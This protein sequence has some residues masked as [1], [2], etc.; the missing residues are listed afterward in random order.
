MKRIV[1]PGQRSSKNVAKRSLA[2]LHRCQR[3]G[4]RQTVTSAIHQSS[5]KL[6]S[7]PPYP[8][9]R[10]YSRD[11]AVL[12]QKLLFEYAGGSEALKNGRCP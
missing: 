8:L 10:N 12:V 2:P 7:C 9:P 11:L 4:K 1:N 6:Q 5:S 3:A